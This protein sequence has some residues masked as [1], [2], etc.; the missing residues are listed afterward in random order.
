VAQCNSFLLTCFLPVAYIHPA[1]IT[2][3]GSRTEACITT[4]RL[5]GVIWK[6]LAKAFDTLPLFIYCYLFSEIASSEVTW[7]V[8]TGSETGEG[9]Y[10]VYL[11][12]CVPSYLKGKSHPMTCLWRHR[13]DPAL[14]R[15][16]WWAPGPGRFSPGK[17][18]APLVQETGWASG[19]RKVSPPPAFERQ[20]SVQS[21]YRL[22]HLGRPSI[23][24]YV[25]LFTFVLQPL[26]LPISLFPVHAS[27]F[28]GVVSLPL[29]EVIC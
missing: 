4:W 27:V 6:E 26:F 23:C 15:G 22:R 10:S 24:V 1:S 11:P 19:S 14:Q 2:C 5:N 9:K 7:L 16:G 29:I 13:G 17:Y 20:T 8:L 25:Y 28:P 18:L 21:L 3:Y 12:L